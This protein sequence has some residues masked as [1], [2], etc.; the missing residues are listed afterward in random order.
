[1]RDKSGEYTL[2]RRIGHG[3]MGQVWAGVRRGLMMPVAIKVLHPYLAETERDC[4]R[5]ENEARI[6]AQ[7]DHGRI[8]KVIDTGMLGG[9]PFVVMDW[10]DGVNLRELVSKAREAGIPLSLAIIC[11][12]VGELLAALEYAHNRKVGGHDAGVIHYDVTPGNILISSSGEVKLTDW[13]IARYAATAGPLSRSVGTPR[14]M[15]PEQITGHPLRATDIYSLGV[16]L[17]ELIEG[18]PYLDGAD[19]DQFRARVL[20]GPPAEL[21]R[22]DVPEWLRRLVRQMLAVRP[23]ERPPAAAARNVLI[24]NAPGYHAASRSLQS[25]YKSLVGEPRSG[26]TQLFELGE[27]KPGEAVEQF[28]VAASLTPRGGDDVVRTTATLTGVPSRAAAVPE[29][30]AIESQIEPEIERTIEL[31]MEDVLQPVPPRA[32]LPMVMSRHVGQVRGSSP[33]APVL[34]ATRSETHVE[35]ELARPAV[36]PDALGAGLN[37]TTGVDVRAALH[38]RWSVVALTVMV[39]ALG[40]ALAWT[41]FAD[42][43]TDFES[44]PAASPQP[45]VVADLSAASAIQPAPAPAPERVEEPAVEPSPVEPPAI[46]PPPA[47]PSPVEPPPAEPP[48]AEPAAI[49]GPPPT[50][51]PALPTKAKAPRQEV[52]FLARD[53]KSFE[54][55]ID[56]KVHKIDLALKTKLRPGSYPIAWRRSASE[57]FRSCGTLVV[58]R[59]EDKQYYDVRLGDGTLSTD[60]RRRGGNP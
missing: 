48:P 40:T 43:E 21:T 34:A 18:A 9:C 11:F 37:S 7:L 13:G 44:N 1:M 15:S 47:E 41:R 2:I 53:G 28:G 55:E 38:Q 52:V 54:L 51:K 45:A 39:L 42:R 58:E 31:P 8:V 33:A 32:T 36:R 17:H 49:E 4:V 35:I 24:D 10:V 57:D 6:A 5:F 50:P 27:L 20:L 59:L 19:P 60:I 23:D 29:P 26:L 30:L 56:E 46:E 12:I 16:V 25:L 3:G 22:P 14:Y